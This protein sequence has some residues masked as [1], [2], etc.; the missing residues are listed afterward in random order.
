MWARYARKTLFTSFKYLHLLPPSQEDPGA[1][2]LCKC[3]H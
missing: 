1:L 2:P 3:S